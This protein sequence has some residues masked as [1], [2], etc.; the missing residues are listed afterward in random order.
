MVPQ[1]SRQFP[2]WPGTFDA[3]YLHR[4]RLGLRQLTVLVYTDRGFG[5]AIEISGL[6]LIPDKLLPAFRNAS[7]SIHLLCRKY[8]TVDR[9]AEVAGEKTTRRS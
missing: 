5:N 3:G 1:A 7:F 4:K 2:S 9:Q 6:L 8:E